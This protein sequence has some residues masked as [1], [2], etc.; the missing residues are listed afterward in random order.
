MKHVHIIGPY[1]GPTAEA[2]AANV[3]N[4]VTLARRVVETGH[5]AYCI[6][7]EIAAGVWGDDSDPAQREH[8][9]RLST[10]RARHAGASGCWLL[11]IQRP[12]WTLSEGT[13]RELAAW[14][15]GRRMAVRPGRHFV[16][17]A[18]EWQAVDLADLLRAP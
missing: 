18:D 9:I 12:D 6:H 4:A 13:S 14:E 10:E 15:I 2:I 3:R 7:A 17:T 16:A 11:V 8:G 5:V 1:A